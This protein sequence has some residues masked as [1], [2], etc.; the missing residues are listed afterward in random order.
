MRSKTD[1]HIEIDP[2][3]ILLGFLKLSEINL[4]D[5][6]AGTNPVEFSE[7]E[8]LENDIGDLNSLYQ[9]AGS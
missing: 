1:A 8:S 9:R 6:F 2:E 3:H 7:R 5:I 4:Y